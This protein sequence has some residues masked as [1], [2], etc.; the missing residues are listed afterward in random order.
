MSTTQAPA[1]DQDVALTPLGGGS[2]RAAVPERWY[3]TTGANGGLLAAQATRAME[4][5]VPD[6]AR[7]PRSL[8]LHY[9][10]VPTEGELD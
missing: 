9:L 7:A 3:V 8:T 5:A 2:W 1:F 6:P 10:E 4:L